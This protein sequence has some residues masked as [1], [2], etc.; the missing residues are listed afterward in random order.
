VA[1]LRDNIFA[2]TSLD[3]VPG[4]R[5]TIALKRLFAV[6]QAYITIFSF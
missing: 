6:C 3:R 4:L 5:G 2:K 1:D